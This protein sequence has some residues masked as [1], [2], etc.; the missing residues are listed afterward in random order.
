MAATESAAAASSSSLLLLLCYVALAGHWTT[1]A[2]AETLA[3]CTRCPGKATSSAV[4]G[5][6]NATLAR[7]LSGRCCLSAG[8]IHDTI[9]GLD[10]SFCQITTVEGLLDNASKAEVMVRVLTVQPTRVSPTDPMVTSRLGSGGERRSDVQSCSMTAARS[11]DA[12]SRP[13]VETVSWKLEVAR[14]DSF[15]HF[16]S[17]LRVFG[18]SRTIHS[19]TYQAQPSLDL[20]AWRTSSC[21]IS[22]NALEGTRLGRGYMSTTAGFAKI[23]RMHATG[24]FPMALFFGLLTA[25]TFLLSAFLWAT[26]R[27]KAKTL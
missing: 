9:L 25:V 24:F 16:T 23:S 10:L 20:Q 19:L 12:R 11:V 1:M 22:S 5:F 27:R 4:V 7:R 2:H 8:D 17:Y 6:C 26:Q 21:L 18:T 13:S 14:Q 3:V 15:R